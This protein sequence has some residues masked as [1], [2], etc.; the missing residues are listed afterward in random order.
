MEIFLKNERAY[1]NKL[2]AKYRK[3][4]LLSILGGVFIG[5]GCIAY[6]Y[7]VAYLGKSGTIVGAALFPTGLIM[8][9][10]LGGS[11]FTSD[12]L[13]TIPCLQ[14]Q[15][16]I[17]KISIHWS[18]VI[19]FNFVGVMILA[20]IARLGN[21]FSLSDVKLCLAHMIY[22]KSNV[23]W[24]ASIGSGILCNL[25]VAGALY[26]AN[27]TDNHVAKILLIWFSVALFVIAG[28]Q[29]VVANAFL[30]SAAWLQFG[31]SAHL[32]DGTIVH[33][34]L[35]GWFQNLIPTFV[36]NW[37]SGAIIIPLSVWQINKK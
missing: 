20:C 12:A 32:A 18:I 21:I 26:M 24:Y 25:L 22:C 6:I 8:C 2:N 37:I 33:F 13:V 10:F 15:A 36:G 11:I 9:I 35:N 14:K 4:I 27:G 31:D 16:K 17:T 34:T 30:Y 29:H 23:V 3:T 28:F 5:L 7:A 1:T 19:I